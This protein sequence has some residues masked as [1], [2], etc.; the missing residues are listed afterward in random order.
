MRIVK[1]VIALL[2][3]TD[4]LCQEKDWDNWRGHIEESKWPSS[5][6]IQD[7]LRRMVRKPRPRQYLGLMGKKAAKAQMTHKRHRFQTFVG[8]MGK[9]S[10][11]EQGSSAAF[12]AGRHQR[13]HL[14]S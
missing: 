8:L 6:I 3:L 10:F 14:F 11:E 1:L 2:L 5:E 12:Q 4:V 13:S 7:T 9:R